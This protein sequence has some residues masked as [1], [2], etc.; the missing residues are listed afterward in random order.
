MTAMTA[1]VEEIRDIV[2][3]QRPDATALENRWG[4]FDFRRPSI[5]HHYVRVTTEDTTVRVYVVDE[6]GVL[7][8]DACLRGMPASIAAVIVSEYLV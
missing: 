1:T 6:R 5:R 4:G 2:T 3:R 7:Y 8:G